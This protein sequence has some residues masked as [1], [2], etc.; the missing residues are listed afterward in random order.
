MSATE[1]LDGAS[2]IK[3]DAKASFSNAA[4][5]I[6]DLFGIAGRDVAGHQVPEAGI[7]AFEIVVALVFK[8]S[9]RA[10]VCRQPS[11]EP[12]CDRRCAAIRS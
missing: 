1:A 2:E 4:A 10:N 12:R 6:T 8:G 11:S 5:F 7:A 3:I 9:D